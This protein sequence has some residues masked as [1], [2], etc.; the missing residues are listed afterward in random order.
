M[1]PAGNLAILNE[2]HH[3]LRSNLSW[4]PAELLWN[5]TPRIDFISFRKQVLTTGENVGVFTS[6][7]V[8]IVLVWGI[9]RNTG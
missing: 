9:N 6:T 7:A 8:A 5:Q 3:Q 1:K 2:G 4:S